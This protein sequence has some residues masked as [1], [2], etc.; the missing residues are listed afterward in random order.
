M[1]ESLTVAFVCPYLTTRPWIVKRL[2][3]VDEFK[4]EVCVIW[5]NNPH[6]MR[7]SMRKFW[8]RA[9]GHK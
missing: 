1:H 6:A 5:R 4:H 2:N 7:S 8:L 3:L 9:W